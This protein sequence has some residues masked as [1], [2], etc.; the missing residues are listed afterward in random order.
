M[1]ACGLR[2]RNLIRPADFTR[3]TRKRPAARETHQYKE[4]NGH[5]KVYSKTDLGRWVCAQRSARVNG[6][7]SLSPK[8]IELL[9]GLGFLWSGL[10][11]GW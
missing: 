3:S 1:V 2:A 5:V 9:D 6:A 7:R 10:P 4:E 8:R 11:D